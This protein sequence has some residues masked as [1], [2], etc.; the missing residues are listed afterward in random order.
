[1]TLVILLVKKDGLGKTLCT[2]KS[3]D[4]KKSCIHCIG[5][6]YASYSKLGSSTQKNEEVESLKSY[7]NGLEQKIELQS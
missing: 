1:M 7:V 3:K 2:P 5:D 4:M 6:A